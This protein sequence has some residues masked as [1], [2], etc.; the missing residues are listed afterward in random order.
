MEYAINTQ[1]GIVFKFNTESM[2]LETFLKQLNNNQLTAVSIS[3]IGLHKRNILSIVPKEP[4]A[5]VS[6]GAYQLNTIDRASYQVQLAEGD[7][8]AQVVDRVNNRT[9]QFIQIGNVVIQSQNFDFI[10]GSTA[11]AETES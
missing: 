2:S 7:T 4:L 9:Q 6:E 8:V 5:E 10:I 3:D 11:L 1:Q